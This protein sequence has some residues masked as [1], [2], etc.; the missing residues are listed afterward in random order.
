VR[1][2]LLALA[3]AAALVAPGTPRGEPAAGTTSAASALA[4]AGP[5]SGPRVRE[6]REQAQALA[7]ARGQSDYG[8]E[9]VE[10]HTP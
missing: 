7:L 3:L 8:F 9:F 1:R 10:P 2:V 4:P 5:P 6:L